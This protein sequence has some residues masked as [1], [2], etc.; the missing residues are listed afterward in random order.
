MVESGGGNAAGRV[1]NGRDHNPHG[2]TSWLAG[3]GSR[4]GT[5]IGATDDFG[6]QAV[7]NPISVHDLHATILH[8]FGIDHEQF[9]VPYSGREMRLTDTEGRVVHELLA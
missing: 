4:G 7:E 3:A 9:T 1:V 5:V 8:L 6:L 2:F